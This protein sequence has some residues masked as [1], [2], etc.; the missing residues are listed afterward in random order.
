M[1]NLIKEYYTFLS[2]LWNKELRGF[3]LELLHIKILLNFMV[4]ST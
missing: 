3:L 2:I 1:D 4:T